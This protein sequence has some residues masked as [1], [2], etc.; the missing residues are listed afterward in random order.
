MTAPRQLPWTKATYTVLEAGDLEPTP[1]P[2]DAQRIRVAAAFATMF[3]DEQMRGLPTIATFEVIRAVLTMSAAAWARDI[4][5][6]AGQVF[7]YD[8]EDPRVRFEQATKLA[9]G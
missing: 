9:S 8:T 2:T 6:L 5:L 7:N 4:G 3:R 1:A